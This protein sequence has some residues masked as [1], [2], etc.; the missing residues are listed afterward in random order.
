MR[1]IFSL[2]KFNMQEAC[3]CV[4]SCL[5]KD[6]EFLLEQTSLQRESTLVY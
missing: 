1:G 6:F 4:I 3:S 5:I 2:K